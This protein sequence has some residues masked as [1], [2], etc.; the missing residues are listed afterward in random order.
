[1]GFVSFDTFMLLRIAHDAFAAISQEAV[2]LV[3]EVPRF[4]HPNAPPPGS[5]EEALAVSGIACDPPAG[6]CSLICRRAG[7]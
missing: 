2:V 7:S 1:M 6:R 5:P 4:H 3:D